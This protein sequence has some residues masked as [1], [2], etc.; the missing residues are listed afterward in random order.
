MIASGVECDDRLEKTLD[1]ADNAV[2]LKTYR[3]FDR[4]SDE[5]EKR[6]LKNNAVLVS[7]CGLE[8][9]RIERNLDALKGEKIPYFVAS[10]GQ[11]EQVVL[12]RR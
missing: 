1:I 9:Q 2:I 5:L 12:R 11:K 7:C 6:N 10:S 8:N 3:Q 4:I